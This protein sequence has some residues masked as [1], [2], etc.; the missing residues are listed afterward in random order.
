MA[1]LTLQKKA[2]LCFRSIKMPKGSYPD[3]VLLA[4]RCTAQT[5]FPGR[6][7]LQ[8]QR[9]EQRG[10]PRW[11][12]LQGLPQ[13]Q[14]A[15]LPEHAVFPGWSAPC[16]CLQKTDYKS[17]SFCLMCGDRSSPLWCLR[18]TT[19]R[20]QLDFLLCQIPCSPLTFHRFWSLISFYI[21]SSVF[22][23]TFRKPSF[24]REE[25]VQVLL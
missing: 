1:S 20:L 12:L 25:E 13:P 10:V 6:M 17:G 15:A 8:L 7:C 9:C 21:Q 2:I 24:W 18:F 5:P 19:T 14:R 4:Q 22:I 3:R 11:G 16:D 23:L